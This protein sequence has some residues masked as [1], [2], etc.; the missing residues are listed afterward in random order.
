MSRSPNTKWL[1]AKLLATTCAA[2]AGLLTYEESVSDLARDHRASAP[3]PLVEGSYLLAWIVAA[4]AVIFGS[5]SLGLAVLRLATGKPR[6]ASL[7]RAALWFGVLVS[8]VSAYALL[9][10][11]V[12]RFMA[13]QGP[14]RSNPF[15]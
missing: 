15:K 6:D 2:Y 5:K 10:T 9:D 1:V 11:Y 12:T 8:A 7:I 13:A 3:G 14:R 4:V